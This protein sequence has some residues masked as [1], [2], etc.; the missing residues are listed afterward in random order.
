MSGA[1]ITAISLARPRRRKPDTEHPIVYQNLFDDAAAFDDSSLSSGSSRRKGSA[2]GGPNAGIY[3][4]PIALGGLCVKALFLLTSF[5]WP[6]IAYGQTTLSELNDFADRVCQRAPMEGKSSESELSAGAKGDLTG[7]LK[8]TFGLGFDARASR[9]DNS[10]SGIQ[11]EKLADALAKGN[12]CHVAVVHDFRDLVLRAPAPIPQGTTNVVPLQGK[13]AIPSRT[14]AAPCRPVP[15]DMNAL[16]NGA[17]Q[18]VTG[19]PAPTLPPVI[20]PKTVEIPLGNQQM[21]WPGL[22]VSMQRIPAL[23]EQP[24]IMVLGTGKMKAV[25]GFCDTGQQ[26]RFSPT[27]SR[28]IVG[29]IDEVTPYNVT[30]TFREDH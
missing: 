8:N 21:V 14:N 7:F 4:L 17:D 11:Q 16:Q 1:P 6:M 29:S 24:M 26:I 13:S 5:A 10:F 18:Q 25:S 2:A 23:S 20:Q 22:Y 19:L 3:A 15:I 30:I 12:E 9:K 28:T 27:P